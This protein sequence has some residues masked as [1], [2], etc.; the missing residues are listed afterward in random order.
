MSQLF[1]HLVFVAVA[2]GF[3]VVRAY[4]QRLAIRSGGKIE[5][6]EGR[7]H[8]MLRKLFGVPFIVAVLAFIVQPNLLAWANLPLPEWAQWVGVVMGV[9][10]VPLIWWVHSAL[11][12]NFSTTLH[13]RDEHTLVTSGPY[14]WVRH[15]MY[16]VL[17]I[18][19]AAIL[20][21][22]RN[23]V[24]G[25]IALLALTLI[26][27]ARLKHEEAVMIEKFGPEYGVYMK[28]T[29]RFLPRILP[30]A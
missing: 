29:G 15:P 16:T 6:R 1:F 23:V 17:Y 22:T 7:L 19:L 2:V 13:L 20:L 11:G 14:R 3:F 24:I 27:V 25:G 12:A 26:V 21:L 28:R 9:A 18:H 5:L 4:Y 8:S 10:S 30:A